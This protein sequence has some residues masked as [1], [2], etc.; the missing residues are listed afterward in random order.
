MRVAMGQLLDR[1]SGTHHTP[2]MDLLGGTAFNVPLNRCRRLR[3]PKDNRVKHRLGTLAQSRLIQLTNGIGG[4][5]YD[6]VGTSLG[7]RY[8]TGKIRKGVSGDHHGWDTALFKFGRHV[9]T[10]RRA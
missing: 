8:T 5:G 3:Q 4:L 9:A 10:P 6:H 7:R 1:R 2:R